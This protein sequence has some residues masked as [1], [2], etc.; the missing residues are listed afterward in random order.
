MKIT[1]NWVT[2]KIK[3][4]YSRT[5]LVHTNMLHIGEQTCKLT[6]RLPPNFA[7]NIKWM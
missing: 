1:K 2:Q 5:H 7:S 3:T 6:E 4:S